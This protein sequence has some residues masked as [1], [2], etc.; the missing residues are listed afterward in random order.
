MGIS[1]PPKLRSDGSDKRS[2]GRGRKSTN[3]PHL[4]NCNKSGCSLGPPFPSSKPRRRRRLCHWRP[5]PPPPPP[6]PSPISGDPHATSLMLRSLSLLLLHSSFHS[7]PTPS[8]LLSSAA[9]AAVSAPGGLGGGAHGTVS[10]VLEIVGPIELLFPASEARLYVRLVRRCARDALA[11]GTA[12]AHAHVV[13]R[14]FAPDVLVS[15]VLLDS[16]AKG[17]S[18]AAARHLFDEMPQR[19][20]VSWCTVIAAHAGRGLCVE[21]I[22][23]FKGLL[24]SDQVKPNRFVISSVLNACARSGVMELG[25]MVHGLVV[26]SGLGFDRFVEVG[27]VDVYAKCGNVVDAVRLFNEIPVKSSVAWNA[28]ISGFVE[29]CCFIEAAELCRDMHRVGMAMD[30]V[31]LRVVSGVAA[32]LGAFK[33]STNIYVYALKVGLGGDCFVVSELI[34][35]AG[36]VGETQYIGKLVP[37]VRRR[38]ASMYSLAI[39]SYHSNGCQEEAVKLAEDFISSGLSLREGDMVTVLDICHREEEVKQM[40]AFSVKTGNFCYT[41]VCNALLSVYCELGSLICAE[42]IFK[43]M[44]SPDIVSWA[45]V[46]AGC[47][48]NH[49]FERACRYFSEL[50]N[51]GAPLDQHC[52][53]TAINACT[54]LQDLDKGMQIHSLALKLGLLLIDFVSASLVNMYAKCHCIESAAELFSH[55]LFPRNLVVTNAMLSGYCWNFLP[56]K[57]LLLFCSEYH[58]GLH[59]DRFTFSTV[60]GACADIGAKHA[61]EQIHGHLVKIG[62]ECLDVIV[63]NAIIDLYVKC[64]CIASAC[65]FFH[66]MKSWNINSYAMLMLGYIQNRCSDEAFQLF[67]KMQHSGLRANRVTFARILR[68]CADLY[69][70][71]L[72]RQLHASIIK[73]GLLSDVYVANALVGMYKKSDISVESG[74]N[75]QETLAGNGPEEDTTDNFFSERRHASSTLEEL[76][77]FTLDEE[78]DNVTLA[79]A[80]KIYI[81]AASQFYGTP[82]SIHEDRNELGINTNISNGSKLL[83]NYKDAS[84]Q[85]NKYGSVKLF[86]LLQEGSTKTDQ[87]VLVVFIDS[88]NLKMRDAGFVNLELVRRSGDAPTLGFPP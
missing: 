80:R 8:R 10:A 85:G 69:A 46:M 76:G 66:S 62:S 65:K 77:L 35:S 79:N 29:N 6:P 37:T 28:M 49:Q 84:Y 21:A 45:A 5:C 26:K 53:A 13:K 70:I 33:L 82:L 1:G 81:G 3:P 20:V 2:V 16:Y 59:P 42:S 47:V 23:L 63:G 22:G 50:N 11:A 54:A 86:N 31:T 87:L 25:L 9:A 41:N 61:G 52:I 48:K 71:D 88:R 4:A 64:G 19:D 15:N 17:G 14:G 30:V 7:R 32:V 24:S 18:L 58:F 12:A 34:K 44:Q 51:T 68:G 83:L 55:T 73:M 72:G 38:D 36:R 75:C 74:R 60:L 39:S 40:H 56:E 27:F 43:T 67:S 57:A 78:K